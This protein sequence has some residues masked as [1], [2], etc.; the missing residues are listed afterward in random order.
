[1]VTRWKCRNATKTAGFYCVKIRSEL[2][3]EDMKVSHL[4]C[5][6]K[7]IKESSKMIMTRPE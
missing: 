4:T 3:W 6:K 5:D 2:L 7:L 1:V